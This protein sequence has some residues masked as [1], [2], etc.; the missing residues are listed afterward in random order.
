MYTRQ[1]RAWRGL[2]GERKCLVCKKYH[3]AGESLLIGRNPKSGHSRWFCVRCFSERRAEVVAIATQ[4]AVTKCL[5]G[6]PSTDVD[7][8]FTADSVALPK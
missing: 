3:N 5:Q 7:K 1:E 6:Q 4:D 8:M 2:L